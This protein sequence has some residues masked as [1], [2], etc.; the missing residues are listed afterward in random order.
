MAIGRFYGT[1]VLLMGRMI[2]HSHIKAYDSDPSTTNLIWLLPEFGLVGF[3]TDAGIT[4][5]LIII[6]S[7]WMLE[8]IWAIA[9]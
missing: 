5:L 2:L 8:W 4:Q 1:Q 7:N 9:C 3:A 6:D